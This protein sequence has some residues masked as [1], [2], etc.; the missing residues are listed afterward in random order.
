MLAPSSHNRGANVKEGSNEKSI[1]NKKIS[2]AAA[3]RSAVTDPYIAESKFV[4][5]VIL[6]RIA[7]I[8][9]PGRPVRVFGPVT[10]INE[11]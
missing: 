7:I 11:Y 5:R 1:V 8:D 9:P 6:G 4:V 10:Y 3:D 2:E